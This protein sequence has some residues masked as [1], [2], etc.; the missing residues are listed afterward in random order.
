MTQFELLKWIH[1]LAA[2][3]WTGGMIVLAFLVVAVRKTSSD[4]EVIRAMARAFAWVSW[5]AMAVAILTGTI[6]YTSL[7]LSWSRFSLKGT[8]IILSIALALWHQLTAKS[9]SPAVRGMGQGMILILAVA[10]FGAAVVLV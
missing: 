1:L 5:A 10:I 8:L 7:G 3:V 2:A 6:N 4:V 9:S